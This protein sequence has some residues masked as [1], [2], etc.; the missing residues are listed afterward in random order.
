MPKGTFVWRRTVIMVVK[1][2]L[3]ASDQQHTCMMKELAGEGWNPQRLFSKTAKGK[4]NNALDHH[5]NS[6][7]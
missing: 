6:Y 1:T 4:D 2:K 7:V 5:C 3:Q